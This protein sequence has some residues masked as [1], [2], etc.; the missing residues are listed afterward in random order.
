MT[1]T[2][3]IPVALSTPRIRDKY[4]EAIEYLTRHPEEI[5]HAWGMFSHPAHCLFQMVDPA[6]TTS[7]RRIDGVACGCLTMIRRGPFQAWT[8]A[9][10]IEIRADLSIPSEVYDVTIHHL[11]IFAKWQRRLD[12]ELGRT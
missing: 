12:R 1:T 9:L 5:V 8:D 3:E 6:P 2:L 11:P 10:T 7:I 4:D